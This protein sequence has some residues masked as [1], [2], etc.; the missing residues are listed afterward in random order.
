MDECV[1]LHAECASV[2]KQNFDMLHLKDVKKMT[3]LQSGTHLGVERHR[4]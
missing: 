3:A 4:V 2:T 1:S